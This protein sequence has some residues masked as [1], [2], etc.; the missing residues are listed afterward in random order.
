MIGCGVTKS[1]AGLVVCRLVEGM[2][3]SAY[4]PGA[5]YV[6]GSYY[7]KN[8]FL[9]RYVI[10]FSAGIC[11]GAVNGFIATL[12]SK[13]DGAAGYQAWRWYV[14]PWFHF[15]PSSPLLHHHIP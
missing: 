3:E 9:K 12:I 15:T 10:F 1:W 7:K 13:M 2:A 11:S 8:E 6:I 5:A 4:V 14:Q